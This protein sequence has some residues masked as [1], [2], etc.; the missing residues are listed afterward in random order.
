MSTKNS[1]FDTDRYFEEYSR[2]VRTGLA[3]VYPTEVRALLEKAV[4]LQI[5]ASKVLTKTVTENFN[6]F[7]PAIK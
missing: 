3:W 5:E 7:A 6:K 1:A 2:A 4:D